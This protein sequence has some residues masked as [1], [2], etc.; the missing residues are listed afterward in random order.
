MIFLKLALP[1]HS[2]SWLEHWNV[3]SATLKSAALG[4]NGYCVFWLYPVENS[5]PVNDEWIELWIWMGNESSP[6]EAWVKTT[7]YGSPLY[8]ILTVVLTGT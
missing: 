7:N 4:C 1:I 8:I 5:V 6:P 3:A 2:D